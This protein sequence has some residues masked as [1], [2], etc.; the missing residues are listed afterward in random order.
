M[1]PVCPHIGS[2]R[3]TSLAVEPKQPV[4]P[5]QLVEPKQSVEPKQPVELKQPVEPKQPAAPHQA[6]PKALKAS[7]APHVFVES[8]MRLPSENIWISPEKE[9]SE[10]S[11]ALPL[12]CKLQ[13]RENLNRVDTL[14]CFALARE[15]LELKAR[16]LQQRQDIEASCENMESDF[17]DNL[18]PTPA[19]Q[20]KKHTVELEIA[21]AQIQSK[22]YPT[23]IQL[24]QREAL[25]RELDRRIPG[26]RAE[27]S[28][29]KTSLQA[30]S[31]SEFLTAYH[32]C[33]RKLYMQAS[34]PE[35]PYESLVGI[36]GKW[37][38]YTQEAENRFGDAWLWQYV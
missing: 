25:E 13:I 23:A 34:T 30:L 31:N 17:P 8:S 12:G 18:L 26:R 2:L 11:K 22:E 10:P 32:T 37:Q 9:T 24:E 28:K 38:A 7:E 5:K 36:W 16:L 14:L 21:K 1:L 4:E 15:D 27:H 3:V 29:T 6:A 35:T 20:S 33:A 19:L